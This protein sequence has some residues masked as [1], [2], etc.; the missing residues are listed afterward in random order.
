MKHQMTTVLKMVAEKA[1]VARAALC[2]RQ[3]QVRLRYISLQ[4]RPMMR[5]PSLRSFH[6]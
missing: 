3:V 6:H 1:A 5:P 2:L 4:G